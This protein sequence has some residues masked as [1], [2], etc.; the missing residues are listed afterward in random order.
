[1]DSGTVLRR[2][3]AGRRVRPGSMIATRMQVFEAAEQPGDRPAKG[4]RTLYKASSMGDLMGGAGGQG[5]TQTTPTIAGGTGC[6]KALVK[7]VICNP[8]TGQAVPLP[9]L[10]SASSLLQCIRATALGPPTKPRP[11]HAPSRV[12]STSST[13]SDYSSRSQLTPPC[14]EEDSAELS[15]DLTDLP[16][17]SPTTGVSRQR[18]AVG[19][20]KQLFESQS[21]LHTP[22]SR[23]T[24]LPSLPQAPGHRVAILPHH[25]QVQTLQRTGVTGLTD[26]ASANTIP[27]SSCLRT[28]QTGQTGKAKVPL[29]PPPVKQVRIVEPESNRVAQ[30]KVPLLPPSSSRPHT[31]AQCSSSPPTTPSHPI[32][33]DIPPPKPPRAAHRI[34]LAQ[35]KQVEPTC[36]CVCTCRR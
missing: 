26:L 2:A 33:S 32:P 4:P 16:Q 22:L 34:R 8:S 5:R 25:Q 12:A 9:H 23:A 27:R 28:S 15:D 30:R 21:S 11:C 3:T 36:A 1:M 29:L 20:L 18:G 19:N 10:P 6:E 24:S 35:L 14:C 7:P 13:D 31:T 17:T